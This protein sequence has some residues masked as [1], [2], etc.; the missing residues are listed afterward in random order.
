MESLNDVVK[1][2]NEHQLHRLYEAADDH[3]TNSL[4]ALK[5]NDLDKALV[6]ATLYNAE[7]I[8]I[9]NFLAEKKENL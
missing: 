7:N 8:R 9:S 4:H 3:R 5:Q 2:A 1:Q 6:Y